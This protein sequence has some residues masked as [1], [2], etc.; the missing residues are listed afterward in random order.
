MEVIVACTMILVLAV[1]AAVCGIYC[2]LKDNIKNVGEEIKSLRE[3]DL[4]YLRELKAIAE[5]HESNDELA[6]E[7]IKSKCEAIEIFMKK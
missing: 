3:H 1:L 6:H 5:K 7:Q 2:G 4:E